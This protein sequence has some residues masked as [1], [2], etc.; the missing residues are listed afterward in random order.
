MTLRPEAHPCLFCGKPILLEPAGAL[1][2][3]VGRWRITCSEDCEEA[4]SLK[5]NTPEAVKARARES[6]DG[7]PPASWDADSRA[8]RVSVEQYVR[9]LGLLGNMAAVERVLL[10][11]GVLL[12]EQEQREGEVVEGVV[13]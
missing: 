1:A 4:F 13:A 7:M 6:E 9:L 3:P 2:L 8:L 10:R 12:Q 5:H 11:L